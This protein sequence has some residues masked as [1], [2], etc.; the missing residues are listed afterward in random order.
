MSAD[1]R[2]NPAISVVRGVTSKE[3]ADHNN[4]RS[5]GPNHPLRNRYTPLKLENLKVRNC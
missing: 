3:F 4:P 5:P 1:L 2:M